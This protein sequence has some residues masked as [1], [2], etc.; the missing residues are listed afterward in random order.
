LTKNFALLFAVL[1]P[2]KNII[3]II[4]TGLARKVNR[5]SLP[6]VCVQFGFLVDDISLLNYKKWKLFHKTTPFVGA[7][8]HRSDP[9][10]GRSTAPPGSPPFFGMIHGPQKDGAP[11]EPHGHGTRPK[12]PPPKSGTPPK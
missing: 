4:D 6:K 5:I 12:K 7:P 3:S 1:Q 10:D 2:K 9:L 8:N 11:K